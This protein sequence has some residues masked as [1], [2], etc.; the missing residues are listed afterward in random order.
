MQRNS[1]DILMV[2]KNE[3]RIRWVSLECNAKY[4]SLNNQSNLF[5]LW[6]M[7]PTVITD[8]HIVFELNYC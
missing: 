7:Q 4:D 2:E 3:S 6:T 1:T 5:N 8:K